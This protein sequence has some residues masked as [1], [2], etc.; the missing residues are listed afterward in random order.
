MRK[1]TIL[2]AIVTFLVTI[3]TF[4]AFVIEEIFCL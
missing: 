4:V 3:M 2:S 1:A